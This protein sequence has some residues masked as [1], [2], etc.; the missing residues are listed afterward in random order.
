M[1]LAHFFPQTGFCF[2][3]VA[4]SITFDSWLWFS[5]TFAILWSTLSPLGPVCSFWQWFDQMISRP[6]TSSLQLAP[7]VQL[8]RKFLNVLCLAR[9]HQWLWLRLCRCLEE[10]VLMIKLKIIPY[11][12]QRMRVI[13]SFFQTKL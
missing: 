11:V 8:R 12:Y 2:W 5:V 6:W 9:P 10:I 3:Y 4:Y 13:F 1:F 7:V